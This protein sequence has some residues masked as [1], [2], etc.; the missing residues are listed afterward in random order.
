MSPIEKTGRSSPVGTIVGGS[1]VN[2]SPF[3]EYFNGDAGAGVGGSHQAG[4][5]AL[6]V[7][8]LVE[9][10]GRHASRRHSI[11]SAGHR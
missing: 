1:G 11:F 10:G 5:T 7:S 2:F 4:W 3:H 6:I 8:R 9:Y